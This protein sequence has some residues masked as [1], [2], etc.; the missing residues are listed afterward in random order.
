MIADL[1]LDFAENLG[2]KLANKASQQF[3]GSPAS[4]NT[5]SQQPIPTD[6]QPVQTVDLKPTDKIV[7]R[8]KPFKDNEN[9]T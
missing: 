3:S 9:S 4:G 2:K 7:Y 6:L 8:I 1:I 5:P